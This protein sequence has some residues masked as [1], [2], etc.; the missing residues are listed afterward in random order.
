MPTSTMSAYANTSGVDVCG[1]RVV[2]T[3]YARF[4]MYC[5]ISV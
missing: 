2:V 1:S 5:Q 3:P 4:D